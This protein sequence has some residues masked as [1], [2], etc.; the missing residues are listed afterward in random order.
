MDSSVSRKKGN[1][2]SARV[3]S[4]FN[5]PLPAVRV[6]YPHV[7]FYSLKFASRKCCV[8]SHVAGIH[9]NDP[10][11]SARIYWFTKGL[12]P[13]PS[14]DLFLDFF[15]RGLLKERLFRDKPRATGALRAKFLN[16]IRQID[17]MKMRRSFDNMEPRNQIY[18][19]ENDSRF[20]RMMYCQFFFQHETK[21]VSYQQCHV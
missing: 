20:Q 1:L 15:S 11:F 10:E 2:V 18:L 12:W 6:S 13:P 4:Y 8:M 9:G 16:E 14:P 19:A 5:L 21:Y 7:P 3:P 17:S